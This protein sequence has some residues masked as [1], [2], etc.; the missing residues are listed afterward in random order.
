MSNSK[1]NEVETL[2][3][4][5]DALALSPRQRFDL[6]LTAPCYP[7]PSKKSYAESRL[8]ELLSF[9]QV[10]TLLYTY[11]WDS[12]TK[13]SIPSGHTVLPSLDIEKA[14]DELRFFLFQYYGAYPNLYSK[15][16]LDKYDT[17]PLHELCKKWRK[18]VSTP[19]GVT[20]VIN[21]YKR[22]QLI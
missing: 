4:S 17:T 2:L 5:K 15:Y 13:L 11:Y 12:D 7:V 1:N 22:W 6:L 14:V 21:L 8:K 18:S 10:V 9:Y 19:S 3:Y 16:N 20:R